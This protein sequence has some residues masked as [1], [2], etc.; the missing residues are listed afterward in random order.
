MR[1]DLGVSPRL[2]SEACVVVGRQTAAI[3]LAVVS[4]KPREH[5]T[6]GAGGYFAAMIKRA[7]TGALHLDRS[8]WKL[9]R[10]WLDRIAREMSGQSGRARQ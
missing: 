10:D 6:R 4:T 7:K 1:V 2:W 3:A 9:R 5:F 8:L